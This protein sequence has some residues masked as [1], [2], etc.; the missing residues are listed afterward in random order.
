VHL[1]FRGIGKAEIDS[2]V[3]VDLLPGGFEL[4]LD[5]RGPEPVPGGSGADAQAQAGGRQ[6]GEP[7]EPKETEE[8]DEQTEGN[9]T[10]WVSP[11][12]GGKRSSWLPE[13][14]D[15]REDR[16]VLYGALDKDANEFVYRIKATN[17][18]T[19]VVPPAYG[20]G[21]YNRALKARTPGGSITV[22]KR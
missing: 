12:G 3:F 14:V 21:M 7:N 13:Y 9:V 19:Y 20:E 16:V 8:G 1:K 2:V 6:G 10:R 18:G 11:I 4:V 17:A 5:P 22:E 15:L